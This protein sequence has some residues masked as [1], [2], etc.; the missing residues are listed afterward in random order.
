[1]EQN[2]LKTSSKRVTKETKGAIEVTDN[3]IGDKITDEFKKVAS[4]K[5][6]KSK[7]RDKMFEEVSDIPQKVYI[8]PENPQQLLMILDILMYIK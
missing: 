1:M 4:N 7:N 5:S 3:L 8:L 6:K 2:A